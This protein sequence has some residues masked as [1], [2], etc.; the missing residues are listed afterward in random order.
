M[1]RKC[2]GCGAR[3][4]NKRTCPAIGGIQEVREELIR[5]NNTDCAYEVGQRI[6]I[7]YPWCSTAFV[8]TIDTIDYVTTNVFIHDEI[9]CKSYGFSWR[10][11]DKWNIHIELLAPGKKIRR[12]RKQTSEKD[13]Y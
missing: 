9:N 11:L 7:Q 12:R 2:G 5:P 4:H 3:G 1:A 13:D 10:T 8:G 6:A